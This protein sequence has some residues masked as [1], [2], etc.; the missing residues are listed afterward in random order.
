MADD[1]AGE[2]SEQ[3]TARRLQEARDGGQVAKSMDLTAAI[4]MLGGMVLLL[5]FREGMLDSML[6]M[7]ADLGAP[8]DISG[9]QINTWISRVANSAAKM[10]LP[11]LLFLVLIVLVGSYLQ[12]GWVL[13][14]KPAP[15]RPSAVVPNSSSTRS[16]ISV[17]RT[18]RA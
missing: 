17:G 3:P 14:W 10:L 8:I 4:A 6:G 15:R 9:G 12:S 11:F 18:S 5:F 7:S 16:T 2:K 13:S 1:E